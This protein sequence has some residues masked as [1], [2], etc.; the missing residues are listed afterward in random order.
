MEVLQTWGEYSFEHDVLLEFEVGLEEW[1]VGHEMVRFLCVVNIDSWE[2]FFF[3]DYF[4][5]Y[6]E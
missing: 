5:I 4:F 6:I 3:V 1:V 2:S